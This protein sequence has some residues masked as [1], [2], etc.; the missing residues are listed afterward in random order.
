MGVMLIVLQ[1]NR[2]VFAL[3]TIVMK[4]QVL[5]VTALLTMIYVNAIRAADGFDNNFIDGDANQLVVQLSDGN[6]AILFGPGGYSGGSYFIHMPNGST[7]DMG[8]V[9]TL[10]FLNVQSTARSA[11]WDRVTA[12]TFYYRI[13]NQNGSPPNFIGVSLSPAST[14]DPNTCYTST[15]LQEWN[16]NFNFLNVIAGLPNGS[17]TFEFYTQLTLTDYGDESSPCNINASLLCQ[18]P[19]HSGRFLSTQF[20]FTDPNV[21]PSSPNYYQSALSEVTKA[22]FQI[23]NSTAP[24]TWAAFQ[25]QKKDNSITVHWATAQEKDVEYFDLQRSSDGYRWQ[26]IHRRSALGNADFRTEYEYLDEKPLPGIDYYRLIAVD[27]DGTETAS[28]TIAVPY[29]NGHQEVRFYPQPAG[30]SVWMQLDESVYESAAVMVI[31]DASGR[32]IR[33]TDLPGQS[34]EPLPV[35]DLNKGLYFVQIWNEEGLRLSS[36]RFIKD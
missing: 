15:Q 29:G 36:G 22:T 17:Y 13:Y 27:W 4:T 7:V 14:L 20:N 1:R 25:A 3:N 33:R 18:T 23:T 11:Y 16:H 8:V 30:E 9:N 26:T 35:S 5:F 34:N 28:S 6:H 32:E 2:G 21:C 10:K 24:L 19:I 12:T 31:Y